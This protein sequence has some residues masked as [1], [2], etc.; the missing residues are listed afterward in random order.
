MLSSTLCSPGG[1]EQFLP[2]CPEGGAPSSLHEG[3]DVE[4]PKTASAPSGK[5][6]LLPQIDQ[7]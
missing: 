3:T 5:P 1:G 7:W 2:L 6:S 4:V